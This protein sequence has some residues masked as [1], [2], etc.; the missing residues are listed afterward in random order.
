MRHTCGENTRSTYQ[1]QQHSRALG[2]K[3]LGDN[4]QLLV[5][6]RDNQC[7]E[8][9]LS[10]NIKKFNYTE[11][12][13]CNTRGITPSSL[14]SCSHPSLGPALDYQAQCDPRH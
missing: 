1:Q 10:N 13:V 5:S 7:D 14:Q 9:Y 12:T 2:H 3:L 4:A 6:I 11:H 8:L